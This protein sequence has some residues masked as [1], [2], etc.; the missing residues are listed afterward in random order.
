[1]IEAPMERGEMSDET[2]IAVAGTAAVVVP[3]SWFSLLSSLRRSL[4][5]LSSQC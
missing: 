5:H 1:M 4:D 2:T 3:L